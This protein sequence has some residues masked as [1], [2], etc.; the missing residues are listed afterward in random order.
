MRVRVSDAASAVS[1]LQFLT[2]AEVA[3]SCVN[4]YVC[5]TRLHSRHNLFG[6]QLGICNFLNTV[7]GLSLSHERCWYFEIVT[8]SWWDNITLQKD[9]NNK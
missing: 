6:P 9:I 1:V 2:S 5:G 8:Q 7:F 4:E 3:Q